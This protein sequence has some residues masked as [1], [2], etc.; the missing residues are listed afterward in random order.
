MKEWK[1]RI[2]ERRKKESVPYR[3]RAKEGKEE[4]MTDKEAER[5]ETEERKERKW[6][7]ERLTLCYYVW[8][9]DHRWR[10]L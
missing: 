8:F 10:S 5:E 4:Y 7:E 2:K 9:E 3:D 6:I 1:K